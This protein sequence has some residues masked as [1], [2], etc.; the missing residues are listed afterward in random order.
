MA[1]RLGAMSR[2][3]GGD[4]LERVLEA[5]SRKT[6]KA[7]M[8]QIGFLEGS[9]EPDGTSIPMI[10]AIQEFGA[11]RAGIPPRPFFR[12]MIASKSPEW[13]GAVADLL[14]ANDY[15]AAKTLNQAG[16]AIAGQLQQSIIDTLDPPLSPVTLMLRKMRSEDQSLVVTGATV[17]EA[18]RRVAAGESTDGVSTKPL[19]DSK[20]MLNSVDHVVK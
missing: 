15:D 11:P 5:I 1:W 6:S 17:G 4:K 13:P 9:T 19:E 16:F 14:I 20:N 3:T 12:T 8:V 7:T 10:A 2:V 18:A